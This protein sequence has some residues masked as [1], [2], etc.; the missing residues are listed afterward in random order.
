MLKSLT[1]L[2]LLGLIYNLD[3]LTFLDNS[4]DSCWTLA[5]GRGI[6][7]PPSEC[8]PGTKQSGNKCR[9]KCP[10]NFELT[11]DDLCLT[12][13]PGDFPDAGLH[14][15]KPGS[16]GRGGGYFITEEWLCNENHSQGCELNGAMYYPRCAENFHN[17]A[18]CTC[19]PDCPPY[20]TDV[21]VGCEKQFHARAEF[22]LQCYEDEEN[23]N[24]LCYTPCDTNFEAHDSLCVM[25]CPY[26][27]TAC[28]PICMKGQVCD[29]QIKRLWESRINEAI[30]FANSDDHEK[31]EFIYLSRYINEPVSRNCDLF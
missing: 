19:S 13:C 27:Y 26:G 28:G 30:D 2:F 23:I 18:C 21:G 15:N 12:R 8:P 7:K 20:T 3:E 9:A 4:S 16:Y 22:D 31:G 11:R 5:Y 1:W 10:S 25:N 17:V 14:C 29:R 24:G 6:G